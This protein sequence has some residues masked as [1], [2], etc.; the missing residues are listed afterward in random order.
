MNQVHDAVVNSE[1]TI[2]R[3]NVIWV[4]I[5]ATISECKSISAPFATDEVRNVLSSH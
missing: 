2:G 1:K 5:G 4:D 3:T